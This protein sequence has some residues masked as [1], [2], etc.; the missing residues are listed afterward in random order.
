M[1]SWNAIVP[2]TIE[3]CVHDLIAEQVQSRPDASAVCAWDGDLTY[4]ELDTLSSELAR[5]LVRRGV[6]AETI[7][8]LCFEKS[9]WTTVAMLG[10]M[11]AGGAFVLLDAGQPEARL[12]SIVEKV[13]AKVLVCSTQHEKTGARLLPTVGAVLVA[14][15]Q[16]N[17]W[18]TA[19]DDEHHLPPIDSKSALYVVLTSGSTGTPKGITITHAKYVSG[20]WPRIK[21]LGYHAGIRIFDFASYS[22]DVAADNMMTATIVGGCLCIPSDAERRD[23]VVGSIRRTHAEVANVTPTLARLISAEE[24]PSLQILILLGEKLSFQDIDAWRGRTL[25]VNAYGPTECGVL[26]TICAKTIKS[27]PSNIGHGVGCVTWVVDPADYKR[28]VPIGAIGELLI[29]GPIVG[30]GYLGD[31]EKTAAA[32]IEDPPWLLCGGG[33]VAGRRGRLYK[34]GDLVRYA[35]DGSLIFVGRK[36]TQVKVRGQ[37]VELGEVEYHTRQALPPGSEV[38]AEVVRPENGRHEPMLV[39]FV[40]PP[41]GA[42]MQS[43]LG[44]QIEGESESETRETREKVVRELV[45]GLDEALE[46]KLPRYMVPSAYV[47]V[48]SIPTTAT[49]KT[50]RKRLREMATTMTTADLAGWRAATG[51]KRSPKTDVEQQLA[52]LWAGVLQVD[53]DTIGLDDSFF[54]LGGDSIGAM[55]L[56]SVAREHGRRLTVADIFVQPRLRDLAHRLFE[57]DEHMLNPQR[58]PFSTIPRAEVLEM[59]HSSSLACASAIS[60]QQFNV[61]DA[62]IVTDYQEYAVAGTITKPRTQLLYLLLTL[63]DNADLAQWTTACEELIRRHE[64]LRT[65]FVPHGSTFVQILLE[66]ISDT[67][68]IHAISGDFMQSF[69][70]L[71]TADV[72]TDL[73]LNLGLP[74]VRFWAIRSRAQGSRLVIRLSH[75]QYDGISLSTLV[76][77]LEDLC[78]KRPILP[79]PSF[80]SYMAHV[81]T[82]MTA[83]CQ[84][85]W[86]ELLHG[87]SLTEL[88]P[89]SGDASLL[90][91]DGQKFNCTMRVPIPQANDATVSTLLQVSWAIVISRVMLTD[92]VLFGQLV[93]GRNV[94][95]PHADRLVGCCINTI[96][97]RI[98]LHDSHSYRDLLKAVHMQKMRSST[99]ETCKLADI[100]KHATSWSTGS[101]FSWTV[102]HQN[103]PTNFSTSSVAVECFHPHVDEIITADEIR[104]FTEPK[105]HELEVSISGVKARE[106]L[107]CRLRDM[108]GAVLAI[109]AKHS[110]RT[111]MYVRDS[112][113]P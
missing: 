16:P 112:G 80:I 73:N 13:D 68:S 83:Q 107:I 28:L 3:R 36:D 35:S 71:C 110:D 78:Q 77:D 8:P 43:K 23:D 47:P 84:A 89:A 92:D 1:W 81:S 41:A 7:V 30:R 62:S 57:P 86:S 67:T 22:F 53:V 97:V 104:L 96:P 31:P 90:S 106:A 56:V 18:S 50:D 2:A 52:A 64:V 61:V 113:Y 48:D 20:V 85:Y 82:V 25:A 74:W 40:R 100:T 105:G 9:R 76:R 93:S 51:A 102:Q 75:A 24:L 19:E 72:D 6:K 33:G 46:A 99:Y 4:G 12:R 55:K 111:V 10:V 49:G 91:D 109:I 59:L 27:E 15:A 32:F 29:E 58:P 70:D 26:G 5:E 37:R 44:S 66:N 38:V 39:A 17:G 94:E 79:A 103:I 69:R 101:Q 34:T 60:Q 11:K 54:R 45:A 108:F 14:S 98:R 65:V 63:P 95:L 88:P 87:S 42:L 21:C